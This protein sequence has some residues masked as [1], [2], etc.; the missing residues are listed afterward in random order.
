[1]G[2]FLHWAKG[3]VQWELWRFHEVQEL[4]KEKMK[5]AA[6]SRS[7]SQNPEI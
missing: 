4:D 2:T 1:M 6:I 7:P 5:K 3:L